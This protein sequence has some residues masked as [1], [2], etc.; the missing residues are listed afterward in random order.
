MLGGEVQP[1]VILLASLYA[2]VGAGILWLRVSGRRLPLPSATLALAACVTLGLLAQLR[3]PSVEPLLRRDAAAVM[4][5]EWWRLLTALWVQDGGVLGGV[6]NIVT[7]LLVGTVAEGMWS[8]PAALSIFIVGALSAELV[9]LRWQPI[10]A[11]N[12]VGTFSL[13]GAIVI[14]CLLQRHVAAARAL[15]WVAALGF[16]V[17]VTWR[18]IH[19][20]AAVAGGVAGLALRRYRRPR[21]PLRRG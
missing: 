7:L 19:G 14:G 20:V 4:A 11:G 1:V 12:S 8:G 18:D 16:A 2:S 6:S 3:W 9:A 15:A 5:G 17:A 10:G 13:A 21:E